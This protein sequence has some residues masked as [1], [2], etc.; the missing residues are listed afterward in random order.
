M[1]WALAVLGGLWLATMT[2]LV[3]WPILGEAPWEED[4]FRP[5]LCE[6]ALARRRESEGTLARLGTQRQQTI[7]DAKRL[8]EMAEEAAADVQRYCFEAP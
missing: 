5:L 2:V 3:A 1:R 8:S 4:R 6:D 7:V